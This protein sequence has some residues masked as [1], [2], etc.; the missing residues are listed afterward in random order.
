MTP[1]QAWTNARDLMAGECDREVDDANEYLSRDMLQGKNREWME[2]HRKAHQ[3]LAGQL[4]ALRYPKRGG[5]L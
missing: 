3:T 5:D 4:R 2:A 1:E